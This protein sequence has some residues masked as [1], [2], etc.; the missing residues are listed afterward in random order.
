MP[1]R[2]GAPGAPLGACSR[3]LSSREGGSSAHDCSSRN[4][5]LAAA[6]FA[7]RESA[8]RRWRRRSP[9]RAGS[10]RRKGKKVRAA[11]KKGASFLLLALIGFTFLLLSFLSPPFS[12]PLSPLSRPWQRRRRAAEAQ[13]QQQ[14]QLLP[15]LLPP[16]STERARARRSKLRTLPSTTTTTLK[17]CRPTA[18]SS[19]PRAGPCGS[20]PTV[21]K[22]VPRYH[23]RPGAR[24]T[25]EAVASWPCSVLESR[26]LRGRGIGF[27]LFSFS[28]RRLICVR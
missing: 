15:L 16:L 23:L 18:T 24:E 11:E 2:P 27:S 1:T 28:R 7:P 6:P 13:Q 19:C 10:K 26:E 12:P 5:D 4:T 20:T 21:S 14:L 3:P 8:T 17:C 22:H 25:E 9:S